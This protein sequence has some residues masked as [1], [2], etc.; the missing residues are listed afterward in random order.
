MEPIVSA[1]L[2]FLRDMLFVISLYF[3]VRFVLLFPCKRRVFAITLL[4]L[5]LLGNAIIFTVL[6]MGA[7]EDT[8]AV[9]DVLSFLLSFLFVLSQLLHPKSA[10]KTVFLI[11]LL[12]DFTVEV[13]Y[14]LIAEYG[15]DAPIIESSFGII[16]F[17]AFSASIYYLIK[18]KTLSVLPGAFQKI[19]K[20]L[21]A[22]FL[23]FEF[24]CY[25]REFGEASSW[26]LSFFRIS[27]VAVMGCLFWMLFRIAFFA[28]EEEDFLKQLSVQKEYGIFLQQND[29]SIRQFRHDYKNQMIV[30]NAYLEN[31]ELNA[32]K[33][34][35]QSLQGTIETAISHISSGNFA[36]DA[37][38]NYKVS[39]AEKKN[40]SISFEGT[41]PAKGIRDEDICMVLSNLLDNAIE[42]CEALS[43]NRNINVCCLEKNGFFLLST[44]NPAPN[45]VNPS[46]TTKEDKKNHGYGLKSVKHIVNKYNGHLSFEQS[47]GLFIVCVRMKM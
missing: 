5:L 28:K 45:N 42:A 32:A 20:P 9:A 46:K 26:Y 24:T 39:T 14:S 15:N 47:E 3:V 25:Y 7:P 13:L 12:L 31:G 34:Y 41:I 35:L 10:I 4:S 36:A 17:G 29:D 44:E 40:I 23:F 30:V 38:L 1:F 21:F 11:G 2:Y 27:T 8:R 16:V 19:P 6:F 37:I 33:E 22:V 43:E 18:S